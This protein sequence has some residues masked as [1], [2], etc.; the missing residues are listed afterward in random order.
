MTT[1]EAVKKWQTIIG[2]KADGIFGVNTS[3]A[4][5]AWQANHNLTPDGVVGPATWGAAGVSGAPTI[6]ATS[7]S[8]ANNT[9]SQDFTTATK[10]WQKTVGVPQTGVFDAATDG[11][12]RVWQLAHGITPDG[13]VGPAT[14]KAIGYMGNMPILKIEAIVSAQS[15]AQ[16]FAS[17]QQA[18]QDAIQ[19]PGQVFAQAV[20]V[21]QQFKPEPIQ[22]PADAFKQAPSILSSLT[23][24]FKQEPTQQPFVQQPL[25]QQVTQTAAPTQAAK[26]PWDDIPVWARWAGGAV[27]GVLLM[28]II[29]PSK[30]KS[31]GSTPAP[32]APTGGK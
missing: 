13:I 19:L 11:A 14:W 31:S 5:R 20:P 21:D 10:T 6:K 12:T 23:S 9:Q 27:A 17:P 8:I 1:L 2:V 16:A 30:K 3:I 25:T 4:T 22:I 7:G 18:L 15:V 28:G 32:A 26:K 24:A 29:M